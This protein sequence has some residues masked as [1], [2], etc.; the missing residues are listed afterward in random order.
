[1]I[2]GMSAQVSDRPVNIEEIETVRTQADCLYTQEQVERAVDH[3]AAEISQRLAGHNPLVL[4]VLIG[5]IIPTAS[6]LTRLDFPLQVDYVHA[7]RY[8]GNTS[9]GKLH[10]LREPGDLSGRSVLLIDDILD[11]G[12]TLKAIAATCHG[13]GASEVLTAVLVDKQVNR[14]D[15]LKQADFTG[16]TV[17]N[18]YV[19][20]CGMDYKG[21]LRNLPGIYAVKGM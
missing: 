10:W 3:M 7:S 15:G 13:A 5:G 21:Y 17:P 20:G 6:L 14:D 12:H 11:E 18:R 8:R 2:P 9:G 19:F 4:S 1:M 16:V